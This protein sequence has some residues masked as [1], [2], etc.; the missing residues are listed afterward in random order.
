MRVRGGWRLVVSLRSRDCT[1]IAQMPPNNSFKS[2]SKHVSIAL[3]RGG[4]SQTVDAI[5]LDQSR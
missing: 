2:N 4:L 5:F 3:L 1:M